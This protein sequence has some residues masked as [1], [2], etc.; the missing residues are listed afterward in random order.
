M[1][2]PFVTFMMASLFLGSGC[3]PYEFVAHKNKSARTDSIQNQAVVQDT[4][5]AVLPL[6]YQKKYERRHGLLLGCV[7][8]LAGLYLA[9]HLNMQAETL[10][11]ETL[12]LGGGVGFICGYLIG[13]AAG[14]SYARKKYRLDQEN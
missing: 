8:S 12:A 7:G 6:D 4:N 14:R 1:K 11:Y 3:T 2:L 9:L 5:L 10:Q 13:R